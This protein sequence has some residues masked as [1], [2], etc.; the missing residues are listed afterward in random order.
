MSALLGSATSLVP[1]YVKLKGT[2][3]LC[4]CEGRPSEIAKGQLFWLKGKGRYQVREEGEGG[5]GGEV[6]GRFAH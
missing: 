6:V 3:N 2:C 4:K 5:E 1:Q